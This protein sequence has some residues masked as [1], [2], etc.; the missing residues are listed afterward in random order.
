MVSYMSMP[1]VVQLH[2]HACAAIAAAQFGS[3]KVC[4]GST[5]LYL[6]ILSFLFFHASGQ[7]LGNMKSQIISLYPKRCKI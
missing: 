1:V 6:F 5:F 2:M 3:L 7:N 4:I